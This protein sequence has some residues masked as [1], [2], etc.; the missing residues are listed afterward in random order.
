MSSYDFFSMLGL[1]LMMGIIVLIVRKWIKEPRRPKNTIY[2][3]IE[4]EENGVPKKK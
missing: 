2:D 4:F 3:G 1:A